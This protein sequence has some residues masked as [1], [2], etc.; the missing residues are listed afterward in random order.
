[1]PARPRVWQVGAGIT[2][3]ALALIWYAASARHWHTAYREAVAASEHAERAQNDLN[4]ALAAAYSA[5]A[6]QADDKHTLS[7]E[8]AQE[9]STA[10]IASN[11]AGPACRVRPPDKPGEADPMPA[12]TDTA[13]PDDPPADAIVVTPGDVTACTAAA[14][15]ALDAHLWARGLAH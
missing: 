13:I 4:T 3:L 1:M 15:Y 6:R 7:R 12:S 14:Q 10:Y 5:K 9:A 8:R 11:R 2:V